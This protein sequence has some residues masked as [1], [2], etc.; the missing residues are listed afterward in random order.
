MFYIPCE[1]GGLSNLYIYMSIWSLFCHLLY[2]VCNLAIPM[3]SQLHSALHPSSRIA[4]SLT[5]ALILFVPA[6]CQA[7]T[8]SNPSHR[9]ENVSRLPSYRC[10]HTCHGLSTYTEHA[11]S[12]RTWTSV[13][14]WSGCVTPLCTRHIACL[15]CFTH[16]GHGARF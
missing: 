1:F 13:G 9:E 11:T 15:L 2:F 6:N 12:A 14:H 7:A 3:L 10:C 5:G 16:F 8:A 4:R